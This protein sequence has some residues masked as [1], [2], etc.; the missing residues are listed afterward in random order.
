MR[1]RGSST[2][3]GARPSTWPPAAPPRT[4]RR[5]HAVPGRR[6]GAPARPSVPPDGEEPGR[7]RVGVLAGAA[8]IVPAPLVRG[9]PVRRGRHSGCGWIVGPAPDASAGA[10]VAGAGRAVAAGHPG[11]ARRRPA[12]RSG[13][14]RPRVVPDV[15]GAHRLPARLAGDAQALARHADH[16]LAPQQPPLRAGAGGPDRPP[17]GRRPERQ[18][19]GGPPGVR[20]R[21]RPGVAI[22]GRSRRRVG[23]RA[24]DGHPPEPVPCRRPRGVRRRPRGRG[25]VAAGGHR[26]RARR[27][28]AAGPPTT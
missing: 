4:T 5:H 21:A 2:P 27:A 10:S 24:G 13:P 17:A 14:V 23:E 8:R 19:R 26:P 3:R 16:E 28:A 11:A 15:L 1:W 25:H 7:G 6:A 20:D 18:A 9:R 12:G 22:R